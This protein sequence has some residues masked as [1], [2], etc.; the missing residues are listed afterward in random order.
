M[1]TCHELN[2]IAC[3]CECRRK[4]AA[5]LRTFDSRSA[6]DPLSSNYERNRSPRRAEDSPEGRERI[7]DRILRAGSKRFDRDW[8]RDSTSGWGKFPRVIVYR[9]PTAETECAA[10]QR[11]HATALNPPSTPRL[12]SITDTRTHS[13]ACCPARSQSVW[14]TLSTVDA[15]LVNTETPDAVSSN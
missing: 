12:T 4:N 7:R 11:A 8:I 5:D 2:G 6:D 9:K 10:D 13:F 15:Y 1:R 3:E 14:N